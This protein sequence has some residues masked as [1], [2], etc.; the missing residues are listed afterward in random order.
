MIQID[1][2]ESPFFCRTKDLLRFQEMKLTM[3]LIGQDG[4][5]LDEVEHLSETENVYSAISPSRAREIFRAIKRRM[6]KIDDSFIDYFLQ[7]SVEMQKLLCV[8]TVMLEDRTFYTFM[9]EVYKEKLIMGNM[10]L[11]R[12]DIIA[13]IHDLQARDD[14]AARWTD[15]GILKLRDNYKSILRD[16]RLISDTGNDREILRPL[17]DA[18]FTAFLN[19][20][21]LTQIRKILIGER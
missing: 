14:N 8:I 7:E 12:D 2:L 20:E 4:K 5:T 13:F 3:E 21:G 1:V 10:T 18:S 16:G 17:L 6:L 19:Q 11:H 15:A 9:D